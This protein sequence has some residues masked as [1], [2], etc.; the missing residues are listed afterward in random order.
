MPQAARLG[1]SIGHSPTMNWLLK[2]VVVG[3]AIGMAS[4]AVIGTGG[5]AAAAIIGG[6]AATGAEVGE[7][8]STMSWAPKEACGVISGKCSSNV[9]INGIPAARAHVDVVNCAKHSSSFLPIATGSATVYIN[10]QAAARMGDKTGCSAVISDGSENVF[11]GSAAIQ[12]DIICPENLVPGAIH[13]GLLVVGVGGAITLGGPIAATAGLIGG[14][15]GDIGIEWL[16]GKA[17][18]NGSD[19]QKWTMLGSVFLGGKAR[20]SNIATAKAAST[21]KVSFDATVN[22]SESERRAYLNH[23]FGRT[24]DLNAD[25]N[26]RGEQ[27]AIRQTEFDRLAVEG[28][29]VGRHGP[30]VTEMALDNRAMYKRDPMTGTT[31][32]FYTRMPHR[33]SKNATQ[34]LSREAMISA[35][36]YARQSQ[37][38]SNKITAAVANDRDQVVVDGLKLQ[39]ALGPNYLSSVYGKTRLGSINNPTGTAYI[40]F[41]NG[42]YISI[43]K[44]NANGNW[45]LHT[46]YPEPQ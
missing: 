7:L 35:E 15:V 36:G 46:M 19:G 24:S 16:G 34:F 43:F 28:H 37:E 27:D 12:T 29:A 21:E 5:V 42:T 40:D 2:G 17:F 9:F 13:T 18:G 45:N 10:G 39:D 41:T 1:D 4:V 30:R 11:I 14:I 38:F 20:G 23:K 25:I 32:D 8:L 44:K 3:A 6:L 33:A 26:F 22:R 31:T